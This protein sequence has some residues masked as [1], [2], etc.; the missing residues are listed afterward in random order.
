M[1][2]LPGYI[3]TGV[4]SLT[5]GILLRYLEPKAKVAYWS[6]HYFLF[7]L[8]KE[9]IVLQTDAL[10]VQNLG[11]K[12]AENIEL[13]MKARPDF[14]QLSPAVPYTEHALDNGQ[15]VLR[16]EGLGPKEFFTLQLLSYKTAPALL[17]V[18]SNAGPASPMPFQI[19]RVFPMWLQALS[20]LLLVVGFGFS[21]YWLVRA[22]IFLSRSIGVAWLL[23]NLTTA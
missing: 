9:N 23:R 17:Y 21:A 22:I 10:T 1:E 15:F 12:A 2:N 16:V 6:P 13:V 14:F 3:A 4:V 8:K 20:A 7:E 5:V 18:R 11:R 19:Q